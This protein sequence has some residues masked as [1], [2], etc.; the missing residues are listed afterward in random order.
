MIIITIYTNSYQFFLYSEPL[1]GAAEAIIPLYGSPYPLDGNSILVNAKTLNAHRQRAVLIDHLRIGVGIA[2]MTPFELTHLLSLSKKTF[3]FHGY[4]VYEIEDIH[5]V[6]KKIFQYDSMCN[7][8]IA[9]PKILNYIQSNIIMTKT[10]KPEENT[11]LLAELMEYKNSSIYSSKN[12]NY[13]YLFNEPVTKR[14]DLPN[15]LTVRSTHTN[16]VS[17]EVVNAHFEKFYKNVVL[18]KDE[19]IEKQKKLELYIADSTTVYDAF[20]SLVNSEYG[21]GLSDLE[22]LF[23]L[24]LK[25][26]IGNNRTTN[27]IGDGIHV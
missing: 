22:D 8:L 19:E 24:V 18:P 20:V 25:M 23:S 9:I 12:I 26:K 2:P 21:R 14:Y 11:D 6:P 13:Y 7:T 27:G 16:K 3:V 15:A 17:T 1:R 5:S 4:D 10:T